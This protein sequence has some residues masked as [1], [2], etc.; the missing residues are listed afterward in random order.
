MSLIIE[1]TPLIDGLDVWTASINSLPI[2]DYSILNYSSCDTGRC[3]CVDDNIVEDVAD[4]F[5]KSVIDTKIS[6]PYKTEISILKNKPNFELIPHFDNDQMLGV[7]IINL[8]NSNTSTKFYN[9][10]D[11]EIGQALVEYSKGAMY[12]NNWDFKHGYKNTSSVDRY[13]ALCIIYKK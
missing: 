13:I 2:I 9:I 3:H 4:C 7:I 10:N 8:V 11:D 12:L 1:N 6:E 5:T